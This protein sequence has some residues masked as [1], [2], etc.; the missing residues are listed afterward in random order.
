MVDNTC[1]SVVLTAEKVNLG[2]L[3]GVTGGVDPANASP[4]EPSA[5]DF[6]NLVREG[7]DCPPSD[8]GYTL[9]TSHLIPV[10]I[11]KPMS[12]ESKEPC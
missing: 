2:Y 8:L 5:H 9:L 11:G 10:S 6:E 7:C 4:L 3:G 1:T 12:D